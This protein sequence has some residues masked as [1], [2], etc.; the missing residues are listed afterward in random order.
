MST[1]EEISYDIAEVSFDHTAA[2][3]DLPQAGGPEIIIP[4]SEELFFQLSNIF[5]AK[6]LDLD[7]KK[8]S[9]LNALRLPRFK[10]NCS[11]N[12]LFP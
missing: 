9:L 2:K 3:W 11:L 5:I 6:L 10:I 1:K 12:C 7:T 4:E 8:S